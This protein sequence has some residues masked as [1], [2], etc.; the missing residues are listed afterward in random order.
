MMQLVQ[1]ILGAVLFFLPGILLSYV[2]FPKTDI[3][4]RSVFSIVLSPIILVFLGIFLYFFGLLSQT[5]IVLMLIF[6]NVLFLL[7]IFNFNKKYKTDFN[8]DIFYLLFFSLIGTL[9]R[10]LFFKSINR[11]SDAYAYSYRF[12]GEEIPDL[13]FYT[14]M[15]IDHSRF[16]GGH[17]FSKISEFL[18]IDNVLDFFGIFL[19]TFLFLGFI[20]LI[21]SIYRYR[22]FA[23]IGVALMALGPI[24]IFHTTSGFFG[25]SFSYL[26]LFSLFLLYKSENKGYFLV[27]L[28]LSTVMT[29]TYLTS[30]MVNALVSLGFIMALFSK[31]LIKNKNIKNLQKK[32]ILAFVLIVVVSLSFIFGS[33]SSDKSSFEKDSSNIQL[34]TEHITSYPLMKYKDPTFLGFS[35]IGWQMLFFFLCGLTFIF[36]IARKIV[37]KEKFSEENLDLLLCLIPIFIVSFAFLYVN[38]P[39]RIFNYFAFF[40]L[41]V[42]KMPKRYLKIFFV[43]SFIFLLISGFY[44]AKDKKVFFETSDGEIG[45]ALWISKNLNGRI[46]TD[47]QFV[48]LLALNKYYN[49]TGAYDDDPLVYDLFY[50]DNESVFLN[51]INTLNEDLGVSYIALTK[52]MQEKYILMINVPQKPLTNINLYAQNLN[53]VYDNGD[54]RVYEIKTKIKNVGEK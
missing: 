36:Y 16:I 8:K 15:A 19:V 24:E 17:I 35:A 37:K 9:W 47:Q 20:Y 2:L 22:K 7:I 21:F 12:I 49:V 40:G 29:F 33:F 4:K 28:L 25:H 50:Q 27:A 30:A 1:Q 6:L 43:L 10:L 38:L 39:T 42:L 14:G 31:K 48:N 18:L 3:I 11:F 23:F 54:V 45:G 13:G 52:R 32:K 34:V 53:K 44:V 41:L 26:V 5:N 46:F 51:T